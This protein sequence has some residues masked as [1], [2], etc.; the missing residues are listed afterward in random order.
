MKVFK[1]LLVLSI[2]LALSVGISFAQDKVVITVASGTVGDG[3]RTY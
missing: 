3:K 2:I 1:S